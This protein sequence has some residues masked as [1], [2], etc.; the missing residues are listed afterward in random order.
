MVH[1]GLVLTGQNMGDA[2]STD[3]SANLNTLVSSS[4]TSAY[5]EAGITDSGAINLVA[6]AIASG[7]SESL[8]KMDAQ[9]SLME[10]LEH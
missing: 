5:S 8:V 1:M 2:N 3:L 9:A 7:L 4:L 6:D 10:N